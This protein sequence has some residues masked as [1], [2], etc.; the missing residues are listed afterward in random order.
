MHI[1]HNVF[2]DPCKDNKSNNYD[3]EATIMAIKFNGDH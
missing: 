3:S 1:A 2:G